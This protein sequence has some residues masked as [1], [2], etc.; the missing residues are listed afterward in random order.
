MVTAAVCHPLAA[1]ARKIVSG[2]SASP[3][4]KGRGSEF[5]GKD[6]APLLVDLET[7]RA[8]GLSDD[9]VCKTSLAHLELN[10]PVH[11]LGIREFGVNTGGL[12]ARVS[13]SFRAR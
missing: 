1:S 9:V 6:F 10:F 5:R 7:S 3:R 4:W 11:Y 12:L 2:A 8:E 13:D